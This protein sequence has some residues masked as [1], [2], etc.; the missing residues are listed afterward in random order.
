[1]K[2]LFPLLLIASLMPCPAQ[3]EGSIMQAD[4]GEILQLPKWLVEFSNLPGEQR[5]LYINTFK[6]A[7]QAY[8]N[9]QWIDCITLLAKCEIIQRGNPSIRQLRASCLMEQKYFDEAMAELEILQK[10]QPDDALTHM[11]I[12]QIH[13][14]CG[15]YEESLKQMSQLREMLPYDTSQEVLDILTYRALL[16]YLMMGQPEKASSLVVDLSPMADTPLYY[17]SRVAFALVEKDFK[18]AEY[19]ENVATRVFANNRAYEP[20]RR[21]LELSGLRVRSLR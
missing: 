10:E 20:Y 4:N 11:N 7:K 19:Y 1:M 9:G 18:E 15:R 3:E 5:T 8:H 12:A 21:T 14:A 13:L 6:Q 16:C 17:Y 2:F